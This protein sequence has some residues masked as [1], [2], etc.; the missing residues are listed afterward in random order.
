MTNQAPTST[1]RQPGIFDRGLSQPFEN[2]LLGE[3]APVLRSSLAQDL[4]IQI[5]ENYINIYDGRN[6]VLKLSYSSRRQALT[7]TIHPKYCPPPDL[8][9]PFKL[10][11]CGSWSQRFVEALPAIRERA[12]DHNKPEGEVEFR[13]ARHHVKAPLVVLDRQI[14]LPG[15]KASRLDMVGLYCGNEGPPSLI[16][17]ELKE[18]SRLIATAVLEQVNRYHN[19]YVREGR[20]R[21]DV[22]GSLDR[23]VRQ[24]QSLGMLPI[25]PISE[26]RTLPVELLVVFVSR[27]AGVPVQDHWKDV[28]DVP[29]HYVGLG[30]GDNAIPPRSHWKLLREQSRG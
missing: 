14:Q 28:G 13:I 10:S 9:K 1:H 17:I 18:G 26:I 24:K 15:I 29:I 23:V 4:D 25:L 12:K 21:I 19:L 27:G 30:K 11:E 3:L 22:A 20:L 2:A 7:A 16:L 8:L 5:R 6:S